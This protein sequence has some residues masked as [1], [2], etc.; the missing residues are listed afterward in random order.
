M[1]E[2]SHEEGLL[3]GDISDVRINATSA[4]PTDL[5]NSIKDSD[6]NK[7]DKLEQN[8]KLTPYRFI[9]VIIYFLLN[10]INGMHWVTFASCAAKFGKFYHLNNFLVDSFSLI[11]MVLYPICCIPEAY[12]IDNISMRIGLTISALLLIAGAFLK[13]FI[14]TSITFA[15]IGQFLTAV[16][17]PA[18]LNSPGK[19]AATWFNEE[20]RTIVTS[21]C[22]VSNTIGIMIGYLIHDF[23]IEEN[24]VNPKMFRDSFEV[25]LLIEFIITTSFCLIFIFLMRNRPK[26][27][28]SISQDKYQPTSLREGIKKLISNKNFIKLLISLTCI[29]GFI[30]I[31]GTIFN[32][33]MA[34]YKIKDS[35]ATYTAATANLF[36]II[37]ALVV[38]G[39]IDKFK[40][41]K[42]S[43]II[44]NS[45][46]LFIFIIT[47]LIMESIDKKSLGKAS[48]I[49]YTLII[50]SSV[51]IYTSGMDYVCEITYP[52]GESISEGIIMC[53]NQIMGIIGIIICD[54][55]RTYL[56]K[57]R[58]MTNIFCILLITISL[59]SLYFVDSELV[60][61]L[62]DN[63]NKKLIKD[64]EEK[65]EENE[66]LKIE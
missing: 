47:T 52:V 45:I 55:F 62:E 42:D 31:F 49:C 48:F 3:Q 18:I 10:F 58:F 43:M 51:P 13:I 15:Y 54:S 24:I 9:I 60:R 66:R 4:R 61:N 56:K 37:T 6:L 57:Y 20:R 27:P 29:V 34:L 64:K 36:G 2:E 41:Y 35:T 21:I 14:N 59:I 33:Y 39:V 26:N 17:Q 16:F 23:V 40:K 8:I 11:F 12:I 1:K 50:G 7:E 53:F 19:I 65:E 44:C 5:T 32:S 46:S 63:K 25:Y 28:P 22:C 30:N 38:G